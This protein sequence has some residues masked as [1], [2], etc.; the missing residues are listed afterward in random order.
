MLRKVK[1]FFYLWDKR[2]IKKYEYEERVLE[3]TQNKLKVGHPN[4]AGI[5]FRLPAGFKKE[6]GK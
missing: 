6:K 4:P 3:T 5:Q 1:S 2:E